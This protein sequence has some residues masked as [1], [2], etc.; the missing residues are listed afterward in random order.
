MD[1]FEKETQA[2]KTLLFKSQNKKLDFIHT[3]ERASG[4]I[5]TKEAMCDSMSSRGSRGYK[6]EHLSTEVIVDLL[7]MKI[8]RG[9]IC[10]NDFKRLMRFLPSLYAS[11]TSN[12][13]LSELEIDD[14]LADNYFEKKHGD[15]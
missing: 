14:M 8:A 11:F 10:Y 5:L 1:T 3:C 13:R 6:L 15:K 7:I 9:K 4:W 12:W 2:E